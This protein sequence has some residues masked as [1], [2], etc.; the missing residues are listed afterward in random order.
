MKNM[1]SIDEYNLHFAQK[2][3]RRVEEEF[4]ATMERWYEINEEARE[5]ERRY[6]LAASEVRALEN[7]HP[8]SM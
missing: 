8:S 4:K 7:K 1:T 5:V 3:L 2:R 6:R